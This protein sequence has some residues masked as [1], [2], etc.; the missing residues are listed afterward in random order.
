MDNLIETLMSPNCL[1]ALITAC[2]S[3][4]VAWH[5]ARKTTQAELSKTTKSQ[6][7]DLHNELRGF[8]DELEVS[9]SYL[10]KPEYTSRQIKLEN[11]LRACASPE[12]MD[13]SSQ[14]FNQ[15]EKH[16]S[17]YTD[18]MKELDERCTYWEPLR[19]EEGQIVGYDLRL[20]IDPNLY[21]DELKN[22]FNQ[23]SI[24]KEDLEKLAKPVLG[25]IRKSTLDV[26]PVNLTTRLRNKATAV[27][28]QGD[29]NE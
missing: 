1:S 9:P 6:Q 10:L 27:L 3:I 14:F 2:A 20:A 4:A 26:K 11:Y 23:C 18:G 7:A 13:A 19:D 5:T 24:Q 22:L 16:R 8:I 17:A 28:F 29:S 21:E 12:V 25:A 15:L